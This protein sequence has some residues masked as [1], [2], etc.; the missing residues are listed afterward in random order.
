MENVV[1]QEGQPGTSARSRTPERR[2]GIAN[3]LVKRGLVGSVRQA[4][5]AMLAVC[6]AA[7]LGMILIW[8]GSGTERATP[9]Q[10][11]GIEW[12]RQGTTGVPSA[13]FMPAE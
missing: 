13:D 4:N 10:E 8:S 2:S 9:E 12:M 5:L 1:F 6:L 3:W 11:R 7:L